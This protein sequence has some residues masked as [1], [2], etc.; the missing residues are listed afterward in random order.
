MPSD[1]LLTR[2]FL[3]ASLA[4]FLNGIAFALF[5]HLS[6]FLSDLGAGDAQIGLIFALAA[7]ASILVR[8]LVGN[9]M[10]RWGRRLVI[11]VG[12][13]LN[14]AFIFGYLAVTDLGPVVHLVRV[15]H[16][17]S[18]A[19]LFSAL[20]TYGVDVIPQSKR[21]QGI[22]LFGVS[23]LLPIAVA[24][25]LGDVILAT[26]G[27][28]ELF[29]TAGAFA[30]A[31][32]LVSLPLA[33]RK[34]VTTPETAQRGFWSVVRLKEL[35]P[36]WWM[37]GWFSYVLTGYFVFIRRFVDDTGAGTVGLFFTAYAVTA[38]VER[39][40]LGWLPDRVGRYRVLYPAFGA[41]VAGFV[42]L[43]NAGTSLDVA[44]AGG[45]CGAGHGFA[46]PILT[47]FM[48]DRAPVGD[49]GSAMAFFTALFDVGTLVGGPTLGAIIDHAGYTE[50]YL[51]SGVLLA[52]A[53]LVFR[54]WEGRALRPTPIALAVLETPAEC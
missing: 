29:I 10:D 13:V 40:A 50:M 51:A 41:L 52:A 22:A 39:I 19:M 45:L 38:V 27:Y 53:T 35:R 3:L 20:F 5:L 30:M 44:V 28:R 46:F 7:V 54:L 26:A 8:P 2:P 34:P 12:N 31:T 32:L 11:M 48:A 6:G 33:E 17:M 23:G 15:G 49:R 43:A 4:N 21:T 24:G 16:G 1:R 9:A 36:V 18:E 25:V 42:V 47:A 14:V 37:V